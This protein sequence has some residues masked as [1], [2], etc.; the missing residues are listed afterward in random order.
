MYV[1][2][3]EFKGYRGFN[4]RLKFIPRINMIVGLNGSGKTTILELIAALSGHDDACDHLIDPSHTPDYA[5][6]VLRHEK[7]KYELELTDGFDLDK[8]AAFKATLPKRT[9][10][11]LQTNLLDA[12]L[13][14]EVRD[15]VECQKDLIESLD[16]YGMDIAMVFDRG[17]GATCLVSETGAQR[18]LLTVG[19]RR[20]PAATPML[21]DYP[22]RSLHVMIRRTIMTDFYSE[23]DGQIIGATHCPEIISMADR[24]FGERDGFIAMGL[25]EKQYQWTK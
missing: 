25:D 5:R 2:R 11:V 16:H 15:P 7:K 24:Q 9:S 13:V 10:F 14:T 1:E 17:R 3:L 23:G 19:M 6:I 12:D 18:Y 8:I 22:E 20:A 21:I 4:F